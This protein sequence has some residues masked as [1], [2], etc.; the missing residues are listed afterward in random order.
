MKGYKRN[1]APAIL[2]KSSSGESH[3]MIWSMQRTRRR[4][5]GFGG[6]LRDEFNVACREMIDAGVSPSAAQR[7]ASK[8]Y[9]YYEALGAFK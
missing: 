9:K 3:A 7:A 2:L 4:V 1:S 6:T 8:S 5:S